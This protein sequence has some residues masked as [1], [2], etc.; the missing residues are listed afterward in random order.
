MYKVEA[1]V[2]EDKY[3]DVQDALK[4]IHV[5]GMTISQV[6]GC[7]TNQGYSRTVRGRKMDILVTPKIKFEIVVSSLDWADRTVAAIRNAA[8]TGQH[9]DGKIFVYE[10]NNVVRIRT[11]EQ[12]IKAVWDEDQYN[13]S[14]EKI[15]HCKILFLWY[16]NNTS[17]DEE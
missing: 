12:G 8:Y 2:R 5:N 4:V 16:Y 6:M 13:D 7:G 17:D 10:L 14:G 1:I 11:N 3:E 9:G 15:N